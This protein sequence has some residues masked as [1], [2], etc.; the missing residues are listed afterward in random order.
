MTTPILNV[1]SALTQEFVDA[2]NTNFNGI[3]AKLDQLLVS[4]QVKTA[5]FSAFPSARYGVDTSGGEIIATLPSASGLTGCETFAFSDFGG[6]WA[7]NNLIVTPADATKFDFGSYG[8]R[9][10]LVCDGTATFTVIF[11]GT[12]FIVR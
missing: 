11:N 10:R 4:W 8:M 7:T 9:D 12:S 5:D 2:L 3:D 1:T 6:L